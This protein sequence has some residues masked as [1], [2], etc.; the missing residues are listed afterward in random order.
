LQR[1]DRAARASMIE[2][3]RSL[4]NAGE[5]ELFAEGSDASA[6]DQDVDRRIAT[7]V[8]RPLLAAASVVVV[9]SGLKAASPILVPFLLA[10]VVSFVSMPLF[11]WLRERRVWNGLAILLT[12]LTDVAVLA[13]GGLLLTGS[14]NQLARE[15]PKYRDQFEQLGERTMVWLEERNVPVRDWLE[16][17]EVA[18]EVPSAARGGAPAYEE[19][20]AGDET[21]PVGEADAWWINLFEPNSIIDLANRA[22]R[23]AAAALSNAVIVVFITT[24]ILLEAATF[25]QKMRLAFG[26]LAWAGRLGRIT[27]ELRRYLVIKFWISLA[28]GLW[29]GIWMALLGLDFAFLWGVTAF[30]LNFVPNIGSILAA[31]PP[32]L[33]GLVQGGPFLALMVAVAYLT[34]NMLLG[35]LLEPQLQG[36]SLGLSTLVVF[37]SLMFWGWLF[38]PVGMLLS[39][40]LTTAAKIVFEHVDGLRWAAVML[41]DAPRSG[42]RRRAAARREAAPATVE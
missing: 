8:L 33:L 17:E 21:V 36:R 42:R 10:L 18:E 9:L 39:V 20:Y 41:G 11:F 1:G 29:L 6:R 27:L 7:G 28:T 3:Q 16:M 34:V 2:P 13:A 24:F 25:R 14:V 38:G 4:E 31:V 40:P 37:L 12:I 30:A 15:L 35:N 5:T 22:V 23:G 32:T 19:P 26:N